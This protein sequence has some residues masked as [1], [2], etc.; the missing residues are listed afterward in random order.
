MLVNDARN[1]LKSIL[2]QGGYKIQGGDGTTLTRNNL[3]IAI[4]DFNVASIKEELNNQLVVLEE[5]RRVLNDAINFTNG[6][7]S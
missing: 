5:K 7:K 3:S 1:K 6:F 2:R 4:Y